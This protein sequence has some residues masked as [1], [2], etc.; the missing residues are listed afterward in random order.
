[1]GF[2]ALTYRPKD[3]STIGL[4]Q[5]QIFAFVEL[6]YTTNNVSPA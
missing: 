5:K 2:L 4:L 6:E 1:M 3:E